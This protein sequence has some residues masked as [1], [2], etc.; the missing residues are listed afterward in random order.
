MSLDAI[1]DR[2]EV[3]DDPQIETLE[4]INH[5][6]SEPLSVRKLLWPN[7]EVL[8]YLARGDP[9]QVREPTEKYYRDVYDH[10]VQ[11]VAL[12]ETYRDLASGARDIYLDALS[13]ST[14]E[15]MKK[16]TVVATIV[17]PHLRRRRLRH[18]LRRQRL[19]RARTRLDVR[20][21]VRHGRHGTSG[22]GSARVLPARG[23]AVKGEFRGSRFSLHHFAR[24]EGSYCCRRGGPLVNSTADSS[25]ESTRAVRSGTV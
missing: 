4:Q 5:A 6:R 21:S 8:G 19:Q 11:L 2:L 22:A 12:V 23:L 24:L 9:D 10:L 14:N 7:R 17:L 18:E 15:V 25:S 13:V 1:E 16:L 3:I 20:L